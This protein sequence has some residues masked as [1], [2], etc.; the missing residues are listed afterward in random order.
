MSTQLCTWDLRDGHLME[1]TTVISNSI[2]LEGLGNAEAH[3]Q[4][5][6]QIDCLYLAII[7]EE[8]YVSAP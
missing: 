4:A 7:G 2:Q 6:H 8:M 3:I 5:D 1:H